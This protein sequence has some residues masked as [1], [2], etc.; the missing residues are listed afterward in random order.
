[1]LAQTDASGEAL[2]EYI[3]LNGR[4]LAVLRHDQD[5]DGVPDDRDDCIA[6]PN[7]PLHPDAGGYSQ[8]DTSGAGYGNL[9][10]ADFDHNGI[11]NFAD[12]AYLKAHFGTSDPNADLDGNGI[13]NFADLAITKSLFGKPPGPSGLHGEAGS[14][15]LLYVHTDA[16][17]APVALSN[18]AGTVVWQASYTPFGQ[19]TVNPDP[20]GDGKKVTFNLR[21][22]G[23]YYDRESGLYY[24]YFRD[25]DPSTGRYVESDPIGL[26]GGLNPYAYVSGDPVSLID[27]LGLKAFLKQCKGRY[28]TCAVTQNENAS[29]LGNYLRFKECQQS[30]KRTCS[31]TFPYCCDVE[32][33]SC[34]AKAAVDPKATAKCATAHLRCVL[35]GK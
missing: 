19:A 16:L 17:G 23:Q 7:G 5:D 27:P 14:P 26:A 4:P 15:Q 8:R 12:L 11:V 18:A 30:I 21:F 20:D 35:K 31:R 33:Q 10:D 9:C 28:A 22:P 3:Y 1:L 13:V 34:Y 6:V 24:N 25:Y 32:S 2:D 29:T